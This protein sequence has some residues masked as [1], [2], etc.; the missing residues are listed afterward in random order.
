MV[1][2]FDFPQ[3]V[4]DYIHRI[5]RTGRAGSTGES[6]SFFTYKDSSVAN[7]LIGVTRGSLAVAEGKPDHSQG[8]FQ[9]GRKKPIQK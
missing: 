3:S 9:N 4:E 6:F 5:G 2:N 1:L 8:S 7:D